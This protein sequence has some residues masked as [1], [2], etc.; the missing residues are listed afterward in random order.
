MTLFTDAG[1]PRLSVGPFSRIPGIIGLE[2]I[3]RTAASISG[4]A[5]SSSHSFSDSVIDRAE[6]CLVTGSILYTHERVHWINAVRSD[7]DKKGE[8]VSPSPQS[9]LTNYAFVR[10]YLLS[11]TC[12]SLL[13]ISPWKTHPTLRIVCPDSAY[14]SPNSDPLQSIVLFIKVWTRTPSLR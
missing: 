14:P 9:M 5:A 2:D 6:P 10:R 8:I 11:A 1:P 3:K 13:L 7:V 4:S 12:V